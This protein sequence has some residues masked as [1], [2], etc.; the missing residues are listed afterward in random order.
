MENPKI[1][2]GVPEAATPQIRPSIYD[3]GNIEIKSIN[4]VRFLKEQISYYR[5]TQGYNFLFRGHTD[6]S[7]KLLSSIAIQL[8]YFN[9]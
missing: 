2:I 7:Y 6:C 4:D 3:V 9:I 1:D 8:R 5:G